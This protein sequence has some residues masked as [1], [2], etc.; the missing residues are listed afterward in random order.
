MCNSAVSRQ[1][2]HIWDRPFI[3]TTQ[4]SLFDPAVLVSEGNFQVQHFL[5]VALEP[6]VPRFN[7]SGV[8]RTDRY[9]VCFGSGCSDE[10]GTPG[11]NLILSPTPDVRPVPVGGVES[12]RLQPGVSNWYNGPLFGD[13]PFEPVDLGGIRCE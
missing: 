10:V 3:R 8:D 13:L 9:L 7:H 12:D 6:E 2:F 11:L 1:R 4:Q 5:A